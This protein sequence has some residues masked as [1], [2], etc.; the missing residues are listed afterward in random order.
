M[1]PVTVT[2]PN[3]DGNTNDPNTAP[4]VTN[5]FVRSSSRKSLDFYD[6]RHVV[7]TS[8]KSISPIGIDAAGHL[9]GVDIVI[10]SEGTAG[11]ATYKPDAPFCAIAELQILDINGGQLIALSGYQLYQQHITGAQL[12][13]NDV[14]LSPL[15]RLSTA[16]G[17]WRFA[18][19]ASLEISA[20]EA[21][22]ALPNMNGAAEFQV[23]I[24]L[25][26]MSDIYAS[27]PATA[28]TAI[29]VRLSEAVW[30]DP[31]A[32]DL[33]GTPN[34]VAPPLQGTTQ[35]WSAMNGPIVAG[36]NSNFRLK[37][38]GNLIRNLILITRD[39]TTLARTDLLTG[40]ITLKLDGQEMDTL[41]IDL[42]RER[43]FRQGLPTETGV[44]TFSFADDFNEKVG[45]EMRNRWLATMASSKVEL[46]F[47]STGPG[48][49]EVITNDVAAVGAVG[50]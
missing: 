17:G 19:R 20:R 15:Y 38:L 26:S 36:T 41:S 32:T 33:N 12:G 40:T 9:R 11:A 43:M 47:T 46:T 29:R 10:E 2:R 35:M 44:Y 45:H 7:G 21:L 49:L 24:V 6:E 37:R 30:T 14:K 5:P 23:K 1:P 39:P 31:P 25:A 27:A 4:P 34:A 50:L 16:D 28:P 8:Q 13:N 42:L 22:G 48:I 3:T 18:V